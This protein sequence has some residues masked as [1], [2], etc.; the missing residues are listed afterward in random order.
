M[1]SGRAGFNFFHWHLN[2]VF[3]TCKKEFNKNATLDF[4]MEIFISQ[5]RQKV[6]IN[7]HRLIFAILSCQNHISPQKLTWFVPSRPQSV[8]IN[9]W[10]SFDYLKAW[11]W[12]YH[13]NHGKTSQQLASLMTF[14]IFKRKL[15][16]NQ[17]NLIFHIRLL[18]DILKHVSWHWTLQIVFFSLDWSSQRLKMPKSSFSSPLSTFKPASSI[19]T[20]LIKSIKVP[21]G[22]LFALYEGFQQ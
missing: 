11:L 5:T 18:N 16:Q 15:L 13:W 17:K 7:G 22:F 12:L 14:S 9:L 6:L 4:W 19:S 21:M 3:L 20:A 8:E 1:F 10:K 2:G